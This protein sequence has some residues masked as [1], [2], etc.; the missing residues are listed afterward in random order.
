MQVLLLCSNY[1]HF[2][3]AK[4]LELEEG[5]ASLPLAFISPRSSS[6][7]LLPM[8]GSHC[9]DTG[10]CLTHFPEF[11]HLTP[12]NLF[13]ATWRFAHAPCYYSSI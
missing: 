12:P 1:A 10:C 8:G 7:L 11:S 4:L 2:I 13:V 3:I 6:M 9:P 5:Q